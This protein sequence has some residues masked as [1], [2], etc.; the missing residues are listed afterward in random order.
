M[1]NKKVKVFSLVIL[2][3]CFFVPGTYADTSSTDNVTITVPVSCSISSTVNSTHSATVNLGTYEDE[4]GETTFK[5][6][7]N[8]ANGFAVYAIGYSGETYGNTTMVPSNLPA[9]SGIVTGTATSGDTSNWAMKLTAVSGDYQPTLGTG[10]NVYHAVPDDYTKVANLNASTDAV[11]G[12]QFKSTYA[13]YISQSQPADTYT[14]KVKYTVVH[15]ADA[16]APD[17]LEQMQNLSSTSCTSTPIRVRDNRDKHVYIIQRLEDGNCWMMENLDLGRT[18]LTTD[19]TSENTNLATTIAAET[20]NG[21]RKTTGAITYTDGE[22]IPV[23]TENSLNGLDMDPT[24]GTSYGTLYNYFAASAGTISGNSNSNDAVYDICPAGWRLP[25]GGSTGEFANLYSYYNSNAL[26]RAP[27]GSGA[28]FALAGMINAA[29]GVVQGQGSNGLYWSSTRNDNTKMYRLFVSTSSVNPGGNYART[30]GYSVRCILDELVMQ[31]VSLWGSDVG[32]GEEVVVKDARDGKIYTVA[33]LADGN[34]WMTQNLDFDI[35]STKTYT[36]ADTDISANW[37][38]S[39][40]TYATNDTTWNNSHTTPESYDPGDYYFDETGFEKIQLLNDY[41]DS[42]YNESCNQ[43]LY[44]QLPDDCIDF[45][46]TCD[47]LFEEC[48]W[49]AW[50]TPKSTSGDSHYHFG[51][52]YNWTAALATNNSSSYS[53]NSTPVN[54]SICPAGWTLPRAGYGEDSFY[55]LFNEYDT[56]IDASNFAWNNPQNSP[57]YLTIAGGAGGIYSSGGYYWTAVTYNQNDAY[58]VGLYLGSP[59]NPVSNPI[60]RYYGIPVRCIARPV[61]STVTFVAP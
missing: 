16:D 15:P 22:F 23:T 3:S 41:L 20:F 39:T 40:S 7:C 24:S 10:F 4:I 8:D 56:K 30:V 11:S 21:W 33:R 26:M 46:N 55:A 51:N 17:Y 32:A 27:I 31:D 52:Y 44:A 25:T 5:I 61:T 19:L 37:T 50:P 45:L 42:C 29:S 35:D 49:D 34:L 2:I 57:R 9:A 36:S 59:V 18:D 53:G 43:T 13:V 60:I 1:K 47:V 58:G 6:L 54:Q 28:A 12:S 14:G 48:D 38:P